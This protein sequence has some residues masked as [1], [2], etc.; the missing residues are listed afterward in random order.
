MFFNLSARKHHGRRLVSHTPAKI[1]RLRWLSQHV[2]KRNL[3]TR[4]PGIRLSRTGPRPTRGHPHGLLGPRGFPLCNVKRGFPIPWRFRGRNH[5]EHFKMWF[6][7][8]RW[9]FRRGISRGEGTDEVFVGAT[10]YT[11]IR[12][13]EVSSMRLDKRGKYLGAEV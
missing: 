7:F 5:G 10:A 1:S 12:H 8:S 4:L 9:V 6:L 11:K 3:A 13:G 2:E